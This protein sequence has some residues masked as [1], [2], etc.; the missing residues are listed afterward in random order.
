MMMSPSFKNLIE[1]IALTFAL[2]GGG[3]VA[4]WLGRRT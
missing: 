2:L 3:S 1:S 4:E